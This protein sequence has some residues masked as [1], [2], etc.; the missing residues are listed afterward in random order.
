MLPAIHVSK[1]YLFYYIPFI[2][3]FL[4]ILVPIPVAVV[5]GTYHKHR[6]DAVITDRIKRR[7][8]LLSCFL[9]LD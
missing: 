1:L 4:L 9:T 3:L 6:Y 7:T 5:Y 2:L 8:A